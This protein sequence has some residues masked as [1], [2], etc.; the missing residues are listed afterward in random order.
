MQDRRRRTWALV[1]IAALLAPTGY[2]FL[3]QNWL[4][5]AIGVTGL[6]VVRFG[7]FPS[8]EADRDD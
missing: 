6:L 8:N 1:V 5:A 7:L 4:L 2:A 3:T